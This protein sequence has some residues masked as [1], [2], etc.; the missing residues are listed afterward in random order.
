MSAAAAAVLGAAGAVAGLGAGWL[1]VELERR[2]RLEEEELEERREYEAD[3][4]R[5]AEAAAA[6]GREP[7]APP[8]WKPERYGWT[9]L[10][11]YLA[12]VLGAVGYAAFAA[13]DPL[14]AGLVIHLLWVTIFVHVVV[15]DVKHRLILNRVTYPAT[16]AAIAL[17]PFSPGLSL[18]HALAGAVAVY[19][20]FVVQSLLLGGSVLGMGDAKLGAVVGATTGLGLDSRHLGA[21]YAVIAAILIGGVAA[22]LLLVTRIRGLK[23]PIPYGPFLCAGAALIMYVGPAGP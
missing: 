9:W 5:E 18:P 1:S 16:V 3:C 7:A 2:E 17:A 19:V 6:E 22:A 8:P 4:I 14:G 13:H 20:V 21:V 23:D 15:F 11:R 12:P 10:E